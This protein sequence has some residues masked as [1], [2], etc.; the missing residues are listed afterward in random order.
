M[1]TLVGAGP[2]GRGLLTL[3]G[4]EALRQAETVIY[5][6]LVSEEILAL[7]PEGA[8]R[9]DVGKEQSRHPVPQTEINALLVRCAQDGR[10][11]VRLKG[12]DSFL[13]GRGGE[14][15][16]YLK[17]HGIPF[18]VIP[19][20]T[21]ALA[22]PALAGI[23]VTHRDFC[24]S[25][26]I[27]TAHARG[28]AP[29]DIDY[30]SLVRLRG[31]LVFLMGVRALSEVCAGL[32]AAGLAPDTPAAVVENGT[33]PN[34]RKLVSTAAGL[35]GAAR[36]MGLKSPAV[37]V[38]GG[39]CALSD[40]LDWF[41]PLPLHGR[42]VIV[43]RPKARAGR[44]SDRLRALG[45][46]VAEC[47]CIDTVLRADLSALREALAVPHDWAVFTSPGGVHLTVQALRQLG[48]DLRA[49]YGL[50]LAAVGRTTA[51]ALDGYGL[52]A[53]LT[54]EQYD[55]AH[56][57]EALLHQLPEGG[58]VLLLRGSDGSPALP[59]RLS[60]A[61]IRVSDVPVYNTI[62]GTAEAAN[63]RERL[64]TA[65][66]AAF[67]SASTVRGFMQAAG[68]CVP[69]GF[70]AACIGPQTAAEAEKYGLRVKTAQ[71]ATVEA[72]A[73]CVEEMLS[74]RKGEME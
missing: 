23:P 34:Q 9:I 22:A 74:D 44:L 68:D 33:R 73:A 56:L 12:G 21:S 13:F 17:A 38:F 58:A 14:E 59:G 40:T 20:V 72:L 60:Q 8:E 37:I 52:S 51:E 69:P 19:G 41:T 47:P 6:R 50:R 66:A 64:R 54:P 25:V 29:L 62:C 11:I 26:H 18:C 16:E 55:G 61:G 42:T 67:T 1:V 49:L 15:C 71:N 28:N 32:L 65:D 43:T 5:D 36:E 39:V 63:L 24:S 30:S 35:P 4:A 57:A 3:A 10:R 53:D 70:A 7:I 45:A 48:R 2:G 46:E 31:T 27:I